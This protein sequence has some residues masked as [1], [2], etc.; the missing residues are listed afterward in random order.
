[1]FVPYQTKMKIFITG[2]NDTISHKITLAQISFRH[3]ETVL[4]GLDKKDKVK[5]SE[6]GRTIPN[7]N[8]EFSSMRSALHLLVK[9]VKQNCSVLSMPK[10]YRKKYRKDR[11]KFSVPSVL[12]A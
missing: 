10:K 7:E 6:Y 8:K 2:K 5:A 9:R 4:S 12:H 1:M 11:Q 3:P